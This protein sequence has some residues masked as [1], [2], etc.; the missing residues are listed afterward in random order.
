MDYNRHLIKQV[1]IN[2]SS[3]NDEARTDCYETL[4]DDAWR[5]EESDAASLYEVPAN[6]MEYLK[7]SGKDS[8]CEDPVNKAIAEVSYDFLSGSGPIISKQHNG[9]SDESHVSTDTDFKLINAS[10]AAYARYPESAG[11][12][13]DND[14]NPYGTESDTNIT[15]RLPGKDFIKSSFSGMSSQITFN[16]PL[17]STEMN[18]SPANCGGL[19][20]AA[21]MG[22]I[23][24]QTE[25]ST[26]VTFIPDITLDFSSISHVSE[27][28]LG[29]VKTWD[30]N[31]LN[32]KLNE[33][34]REKWTSS[35]LGLDDSKRQEGNNAGTPYVRSVIQSKDIRGGISTGSIQEMADT[36]KSLPR[37]SS[38]RKFQTYGLGQGCTAINYDQLQRDLQEIQDS[39]SRTLGPDLHLANHPQLHKLD[40]SSNK[41]TPDMSDN[42]LEII[43]STNTSLNNSTEKIKWA[44][45]T[46]LDY[47]HHRDQDKMGIHSPNQQGQGRFGH[48]DGDETQTSGS[49]DRQDDHEAA[50]RVLAEM[51]E[52]LQPGNII[53]TSM[54]NSR[55]QCREVNSGYKPLNHGLAEKVCRILADQNPEMQAEVILSEVSD[56]EKDMR[57]KYALQVH[58]KDFNFSSS[59][60]I[61]SQPLILGDNVRKKLDLSNVSSENTSMFI[62]KASLS[63]TT[64]FMAYDGMSQFLSSQMHRAAERT[65]NHSLDMQ[66]P[67]QVIQCYP[68]VGYDRAQGG[69]QS[70]QDGEIR[71]LAAKS[72]SPRRN[73]EVSIVI[74]QGSMQDPNTGKLS[75]TR[76]E[77]IDHTSQ[78]LYEG[79]HNNNH[80]DTSS[81]PDSDSSTGRW[82]D[83]YRP[84]KPPG[85][86]DVYYTESDAVSV[87]DSVTTIES[88]HIGS[89]DAKGPT[90]P[91][92]ALGSRRDPPKAVGIYGNRKHS[93]DVIVLTPIQEKPGM[94]ESESTAKETIEKVPKLSVGADGGLMNDPSK[95]NREP[96]MDSRGDTVLVANQVPPKEADYQKTDTTSN[97]SA[98]AL[99]HR[100][101]VS[102]SLDV[103]SLGQR[104]SHLSQM[105]CEDDNSRPDNSRYVNSRPVNSRPDISRPENSRL[106]SR[107]LYRDQQDN[108]GWKEPGNIRTNF[109]VTRDQ[110]EEDSRR[111]STKLKPADSTDQRPT[112][113]QE[114]WKSIKFESRHHQTGSNS[115]QTSQTPAIS[116]A[117]HRALSPDLLQAI[118]SRSPLIGSVIEKSLA[119]PPAVGA[120]KPVGV[121]R[122]YRQQS[123]HG[124]P[125]FLARERSQASRDLARNTLAAP[126]TTQSVSNVTAQQSLRRLDDVK[127]TGSAEFQKKSEMLFIDERRSAGPLKKSERE[128]EITLENMSSDSQD[129]SVDHQPMSQRAKLL[130]QALPPEEDIPVNINQLWEQFKAMNQSPES[131]MNSGRMEDVADL[132]RNPARHHI[133]QY[134]KLREEYRIQRQERNEGERE[135]K[136]KEQQQLVKGNFRSGELNTSSENS[137]SNKENERNLPRREKKKQPREKD[138]NGSGLTAESLFSIPED[139]SFEVSPGKANSPSKQRFPKQKHVIDPNMSKL[140]ERISK[141]RKRVEKEE[142]KELHRMDKLKKLERLLL[143]KKQGKISDQTF[144]RQLEHISLS[145]SSTDSS[146][147]GGAYPPS[148]N[149]TPLSEDSTTAKDSSAEMLNWKAEKHRRMK[150]M[151]KGY[152]KQHRQ[153]KQGNYTTS[154]NQH[155]Q[156][157]AV[158]KSPGRA[159]PLLKQKRSGSPQDSSYDDQTP[160]S[161]SADFNV[162]HQNRPHN[163]YS[164]YS[165]TALYLDHV[166][167]L[168]CPPISRSSSE[169]RSDSQDSY[170]AL[171]SRHDKTKSTSD[172]KMKTR[173]DN[174]SNRQKKQDFRNSQDYSSENEPPD[175]QQTSGIAWDIPL[176]S[177]HYH[178]K[179]SKILPLKERKIVTNAEIPTKLG[180]TKEA[181][182]AKKGENFASIWD[183]NEHPEGI[184][185]R[186]WEEVVNQDPLASKTNHWDVDP[187][188]D[189]VQYI[190]DRGPLGCNDEDQE[191]GFSL[192]EAFLAR[193]QG[194]ISKCKERQKRIALARESRHMQECLRLEREAIFAE[195]GR[196]LQANLYAHPYSDNLFQP[197]RRVLSKQEMKELTLKRYKKLAEVI[198]KEE[199]SKCSE[200]IK[201]NRLRVQIFNKK[202]Q[203]ET[204]RKCC[205]RQR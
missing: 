134:M 10:R 18:T 26:A 29:P 194:F 4:Y 49:S 36:E 179:P 169:D 27:K 73:E 7:H 188:M 57:V 77:Q 42:D 8:G 128:I 139:A 17:H 172:L 1:P 35:E 82:K 107:T 142:L 44:L 114:D 205:M 31:K 39:L 184:P 161:W 151:A 186:V 45:T 76:A 40:E 66:I 180:Q 38:V 37:D 150:E 191:Q 138:K 48:S 5:S 81:P 21:G 28:V 9:D 16:P 173:S 135:R 183:A 198:E 112:H 120:Y 100:E 196:N 67:P 87:A 74:G 104:D 185:R 41:G 105:T 24:E 69:G 12:L 168:K 175:S 34:M 85:S 102:K 71:F 86:K 80:C 88:T 59:S 118:G 65:F 68:L 132:L 43:P 93:E 167:K 158:H 145:A 129:T 15:P 62:N 96:S 157:R 130:T 187:L 117:F 192:Q 109:S 32:N 170:K 202:V 13:S 149:T 203:Q 125:T 98:Q 51:S 72:S 115:Q 50:D 136:L 63:R 19:G 127:E 78:Q 25:M 147:D 177:K 156:L 193:K 94:D 110:Y 54:I 90:L 174:Q 131:S 58:Y 64:N 11:G 165:R 106:A 6:Y 103:L 163:L 200:N 91:Q 97:N 148:H 83:K 140:R 113:V 56:K 204:L 53:D 146:H 122:E 189:R 47:Q 178:S 141:Q 22:D 155:K 89:D 14:W 166:P 23:Y 108:P 99:R 111:P 182:F 30:S 75:P 152:A 197:K 176:D 160:R 33:T 144:D 201:L 70:H 46:D 171:D 190:L 199:K 121:S 137:G 123:Q 2:K 20:P 52:L 143:A 92:S 159:K 154:S 153:T 164:P 84:Y 101:E 119:R 181:P 61:S 60:D 133:A 195:H 126:P 116:T 79:Q 95:L 162:H 55:S 3:S 124:P